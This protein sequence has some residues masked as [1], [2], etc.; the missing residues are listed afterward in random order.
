[1][2]IEEVVKNLKDDGVAHVIM[3]SKNGTDFYSG[4]INYEIGR[5][6]HRRCSEGGMEVSDWW[7]TGWASVQY[8]V[9]DS[10]RGG[11]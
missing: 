1:M 10:V 7:E 9:W 8:S 11:K 5:T 2:L 3:P 4:K 6:M